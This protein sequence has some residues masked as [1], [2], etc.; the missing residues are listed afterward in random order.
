MI[1]KDTDEFREIVSQTRD[2]LEFYRELGLTEIGGSLRSVPASEEITLPVPELSVQNKVESSITMSPKKIISGDLFEEKIVKTA[3]SNETLQ[4]IRTDI[5]DCTRCRLCEAR[6]N[7]VFGEGN[8]N[9]ELMFVGEGPGAEEDKQGRPFVGRSGQLLTKIIESIGYKREDCYIA[10]VVKCRPPENR[11]PQP[12]E[13]ATCEGFLFRQLAI[14]KPKVVVALGLPSAQTL[15]KTKQSISA[16]RG[17][18]HDFQDAKL[19]P[20]FHPAYLLRSP[21]KKREVWED[22]KKVRDY[23]AGKLEL[24]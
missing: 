18:F 17:R 8:P 23:L 1:M 5:G 11:T 6:T 15:L 19:M 16:L 10:N 4:D 22:M 21:D 20:T 2:Y 9:A 13:I 24:D 12:D 14:I 7:I 3:N